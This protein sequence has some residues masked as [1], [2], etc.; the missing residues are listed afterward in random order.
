[1]RHSWTILIGSAVIKAVSGDMCGDFCQANPLVC[2]KNGSY[3]KNQHACHD[4][5]WTDLTKREACSS[6]TPGCPITVPVLCSEIREMLARS[7]PAASRQP[8]SRSTNQRQLRRQD[9]DGLGD[10]LELSRVTAAE[11][12]A[13]RLS[14]TTSTTTQTVPRQVPH[15]VDLDAILELSRRTAAEDEIRRQTT[16]STTP[17]VR[18]HSRSQDEIDLEEALE[19]SRRAAEEDEARRQTSTTTIALASLPEDEALRRALE[20]SLNQEDGQEF[21]RDPRPGRLGFHNLGATCYLATA[22]Q[23]LAH[24]SPIVNL[25]QSGAP[26][27]EPN[28]VA[29]AF[30][31]VVDQMWNRFDQADGEPLIPAGLLTALNEYTMDGS[32]RGRFLPDRMQDANEVVQIILDR[33]IAAYGHRL[34]SILGLDVTSRR[35]CQICMTDVSKT[36][37]ESGINISIPEPEEEGGSVTLENCLHSYLGAHEDIE[38]YACEAVCQGYTM[39][40]SR[41]GISATRDVI[42][43]ALKRFRNDRSKI[44]TEVEIPALLE[45]PLIPG[46]RFELIGIA[47][48][49]GDSLSGGHFVSEFFHPTHHEWVHANDRSVETMNYPPLLRSST[50]YALMYQKRI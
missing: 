6:V 1:M 32:D 8:T 10:M 21:V 42:F 46:G 49:L 16:T 7:A 3:C 47:H 14:S 33:L 36:T 41:L 35:E 12:E 45:S 18:T 20:A 26:M 40:R 4:L 27:I 19:L 9:D 44:Q 2:G 37:M 48:H 34:Y 38:N 15:E 43:I 30:S 39:A 22:V 23:L 25:I 5:F 17:T 11:E 24:A 29:I 28:P 31:D 13:R 50:A